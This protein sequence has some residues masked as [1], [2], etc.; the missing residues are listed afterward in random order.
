MT[1]VIDAP[2]IA[3][4]PLSRHVDRGEPVFKERSSQLGSRVR[5]RR[6]SYELL[7][8]HQLKAA[9]QGFRARCR[10]ELGAGLFG[11]ESLSLVRLGGRQRGLRLRFAVRRDVEQRE[12]SMPDRRP[13]ARP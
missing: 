1:D 7:E 8:E 13:L 6:D 9:E 11:C 10:L 5:L 12:R 3:V 4:I 2:G